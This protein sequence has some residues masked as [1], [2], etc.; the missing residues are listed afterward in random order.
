AVDYE[1][2]PASELEMARPRRHAPPAQVPSAT[3]AAPLAKSTPQAPNRI[4]SSRADQRLKPASSLATAADVS[5][6]SASQEPGAQAEEAA[7]PTTR[8][9]SSADNPVSLPAR[10]AAWVIDVELM[11]F[12]FLPFPIVFAVFDAELSRDS[13]Y[14]LAGLALVIAFIYHLLT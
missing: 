1:E 13:F 8:V 7:T 5:G 4:E 2:D 11:V 9:K 12:S 10:A 3:V 6:H 14:L